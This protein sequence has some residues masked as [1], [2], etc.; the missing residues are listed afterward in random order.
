MDPNCPDCG[1]KL[2]KV[3]YD[4]SYLLNFDQ[5]DSIKAGDYYCPGE[6]KGDRGKSGLRYFWERALTDSSHSNSR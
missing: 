5:W 2:E 1:T 6:C 3:V 4:S